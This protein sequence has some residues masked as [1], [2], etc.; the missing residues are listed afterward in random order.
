MPIPE[1]KDFRDYILI[2]SVSN[3]PAIYVYWSSRQVL[4]P[5]SVTGW[6]KAEKYYDKIRAD[7]SDISTIAKNTG[8]KESHV[9]RAKDHVF[10]REH[11]LGYGKGKGRFDADPEMVN[12]WERL[13]KGDFVKSDIN[14]LKHEYFE[15]R[16]ERIFSTDYITAHEAAV[17]SGRDWKP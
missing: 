16:F 12:A 9:A 5:D 4:D 2:F 15:S 10:F 6:E 3:I 13:K 17:K 14:L 1:E 8:W 7:P 11:Q